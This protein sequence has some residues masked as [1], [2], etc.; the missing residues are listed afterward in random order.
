M[1]AL[2]IIL[3][4]FVVLVA[5]ARITRIKG[6]KDFF[7]AKRRVGTLSCTMTL[8]AT[9]IGGSAT[10]GLAGLG[11]KMGLTGM[12]WL[13]VGTIGLIIL[14]VTFAE[15][16][17]R[18][19]PYTLPELV[20]KLYDKRT[21][22]AASILIAVAWLG[23]VAGQILSAGILLTTI[24]GLPLVISATASAMVFIIYT[25]LGGQKAVIKTDI[26]QLII[27]VIGISL[28][29]TPLAVLRAGGLTGLEAKLPSS[30]FSFPISPDMSWLV[31]LSWFL[32]IGM[33]YVVGPDIYS[34][35][36]SARDERTAK[37]STFF[38]ALLLIPLALSMVLI[39]MYAR[40]QFPN[41][42]AEQSVPVVINDVLPV[43]LRGLA[44]A[45]FLAAFMSSA[46]TTLMT[47]SAILAWDIYKGHINPS[48][49]DR[50]VLRISRGMIVVMGLLAL[51]VAL[52]I[53]G[54]IESLFLAYTVFSSGLIVPIIAGFYRK[55]LGVNSNGALAGLIGGGSVAILLKILKVPANDPKMILGMIVSLVLLF[56]VSKVTSGD[57]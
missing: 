18:M 53:G 7:V 45:A 34:R 37:R 50:K 56:V 31:I 44:I 27:I 2:I 57:S 16:A 41:I 22:L 43:G 40:A 51:L 28:V 36:F 30:H 6:L 5:G 33:T 48:A 23:I 52:F 46:D 4:L 9:I 21:R 25:S 20:E 19:A 11:F 38:A 35:L 14:V 1:D 3:Y 13:L 8:C 55:R 15:K 54:I 47:T 39:G 32:L 29:T 17:R 26:L 49:N 12:W 10:V 42:S 24:L